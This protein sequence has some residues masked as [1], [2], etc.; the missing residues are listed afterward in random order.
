MNNDQ[1]KIFQQKRFVKTK[2]I[3]NAITKNAMSKKFSIIKSIEN[4]IIFVNELL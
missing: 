2:K 1:I 4:D 3:Q